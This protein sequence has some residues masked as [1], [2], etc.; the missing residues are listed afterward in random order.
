MMKGIA[1][2]RG[3]GGDGEGQHVPFSLSSA[4]SLPVRGQRGGHVGH[5]NMAWQE[6]GSLADA[7]TYDCVQ[8]Q[9][10]ASQQL[11]PA[12]GQRGQSS[13]ARTLYGGSD[14][15]S[16]RSEN[17]R[18]L[19]APLPRSAWTEQQQSS[20][21]DAHALLQPLRESGS[22]G[23]V[24]GQSGLHHI[25]ARR[26][27]TENSADMCVA[28]SAQ[29]WPGPRTIPL[30]PAELASHRNVHRSVSPANRAP[31]PQ[32][33]KQTA[34]FQT[35]KIAMAQGTQDFLWASQSFLC[36]YNRLAR[37]G[38]AQGNLR[39]AD[40]NLMQ[41]LELVQQGDMEN[42]E[43]SAVTYNLLGCMYRRMGRLNEAVDYLHRSLYVLALR[44]Q[45]GEPLVE[46]D[47]D[48][49]DVH[50]NMSSAQSA[51]NRHDS[52]LHH[53][54]TAVALLSER[55]GM[56]QG[57]EPGESLSSE[58]DSKDVRMLAIAHYNRGAELRT[59]TKHS[60]SLQAFESAMHLADNFLPPGDSLRAMIKKAH[61]RA[62]GANRDEAGWVGAPPGVTPLR[63]SMLQ[64]TVHTS[65]Q[66]TYP[67]YASVDRDT[68]ERERPAQQP[69]SAHT[70]SHR[71]T[72]SMGS[73]R[74]PRSGR[75]QLT[76][77]GLHSLHAVHRGNFAT[78][79]RRSARDGRAG[80]ELSKQP[81]VSFTNTQIQTGLVK[82]THDSEMRATLPRNVFQRK[83]L[84]TRGSG[85]DDLV[86]FDEH[87]EVLGLAQAHDIFS[88]IRGVPEG[89]VVNVASRYVA[90]DGNTKGLFDYGRSLAQSLIKKKEVCES[91]TQVEHE[92]MGGAESAAPD[93]GP[94][95]RLKS[96]PGGW[97][98]ENVEQTV[99][100]MVSQRAR[101]EIRG[102]ASERGSGGWAFRAGN[103]DPAAARPANSLDRTYRS[104]LQRTREAHLRYNKVALVLQLAFRCHMARLVAI[105][106]QHN[107]RHLK[108]MMAKQINAFATLLQ[109][110]MRCMLSKRRVAK[111]ASRRIMSAEDRW[112][113]RRN[114]ASF[115]I[116]AWFWQ[117]VGS[118]LKAR[119]F[120]GPSDAASCLQRTFRFYVA[121]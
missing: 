81:R 35:N 65:A 48:L 52:A 36:E 109:S 4:R 93:D 32:F 64:P 97:R 45:G 108:A 96:L 38:L 26:A 21:N 9:M 99:E 63:L 113:S 110:N 23:G 19:Y 2:G 73:M 120:N 115:V 68:G 98:R 105:H 61:R 53:V 5:V 86:S 106:L 11:P 1:R 34:V 95:V 49:A 82:A 111:Y 22:E 50:M 58:Q 116:Q 37:L 107:P 56:A 33:S 114:R 76:P 16:S 40:E 92:Y 3:L 101:E 84:D 51:L 80:D 14:L 59:L 30:A 83:N 75:S 60:E 18:A 112:R 15:E 102:R 25:S 20:R 91:Y 70:P 66:Q 100:D 10:A 67:H 12:R 54:E 79:A 43:V 89:G 44:K 87:D 39:I 8:R 88:L 118:R 121:R 74:T 42:T 6:L 77:Q 72:S 7:D 41:A 57:L 17:A 94:F 29:P 78:S 119:R 71:S 47:V 104:H 31:S 90:Q 69:G 62:G 85:G 46:C 24:S 28:A 55:L 103:V 27:F 13:M 117:V